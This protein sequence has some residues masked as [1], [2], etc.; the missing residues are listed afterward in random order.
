LCVLLL[1]N[2][3]YLQPFLV[4]VG[5]LGSTCALYF[6]QA[7]FRWEF[8]ATEHLAVTGLFSVLAA[9]LSILFIL[10]L[11]DPLTGALI[12]QLA[13]GVV[14]ASVAAYLLRRSLWGRFRP[15]RLKQMLLYSLP[16]VPGNLAIVASQYAS[17]FFLNGMGSLEEV[18]VY[19]YASQI[20]GLVA[21]AMVA[22]QSSITPLIM[23]HFEE[24]ETPGNLARLFEIFVVGAAALCVFL[25]LFA[26]ELIL[27]V[28]N[29]SYA[30]AAP[31][32][33]ILAPATV[34]SGLYVFAPGFLIAKKT[35]VQML[36]SLIGA[37]VVFTSN[38]LLIGWFGM[39]GAAWATLLG[40][41][42]FTTLWIA[43]SHSYYPVPFRWGRLALFL[44]GA[45]VLALIGNAL[46]G[47]VSVASVA[48][49]LA[50]V[51]AT[52]AIGVALGCFPLRA[53]LA[54]L[55]AWVPTRPRGESA[56]G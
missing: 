11:P 48:G 7:Q 22:V 17:R 47:D 41:L 29:A 34:A 30:G 2:A 52:F 20:A 54:M 43:A 44:V 36:V 16:L 53:M 25:G 4:G 18:G 42:A 21:L 6:L 14:A 24:P 12:G 10:G 49:K 37:I 5:L 55:R 40:S 45:G 50:L 23:A 3:E 33:L 28:G 31:L 32:V 38:Y 19:T 26:P 27:L 15:S 46:P 13:A 8:R 51:G 1:G 35:S 9:S 39:E 56:G